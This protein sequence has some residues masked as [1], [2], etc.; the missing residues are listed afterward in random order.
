MPPEA[1]QSLIFLEADATDD[2]GGQPFVGVVRHRDDLIRWLRNAPSALQWIEVDGL[3]GDPEVWSFAAQ[4]T[5]EIP[6]DVVVSAPG[7]QFADLYRLVDVR[8]VRD[9]RVSMTATAGFL[10]ALRLAASLGFPV[11]LLPGQPSVEATSEL[12]TALELYLH[13]PMVD[14]PI[15]Y[16]HSA[17]ARMRG[18]P[19]GSLWRV[20]EEDPAIFRR[21]KGQKFRRAAE[22]SAEFE[23]SANFVPDFLA[24]LIEGEAECATC[25]WQGFCEGYF[26]WPDPKY[27]CD[28][29]KQLFR[30]LEAAAKEIQDDLSTY[31]A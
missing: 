25:H 2:A 30:R 10:K 9:V 21:E 17:L 1:S 27:S 18:A 7:S 28:G 6:L 22:T 23:L 8:A 29:V 12:S 14:A 3:L 13:D 4:G 5:D 24:G 26:K 16:F 20:L 31:A 15:E 11:R 19:T